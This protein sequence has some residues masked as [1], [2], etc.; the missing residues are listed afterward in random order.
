MFGR[1]RWPKK[2]GRLRQRAKRKGNGVL[3]TSAGSA[4][5]GN[6]FFAAHAAS[7]AALNVQE[8]LCVE[9]I[10]NYSDSHHNIEIHITNYMLKINVLNFE[11]MVTVTVIT[12]VIS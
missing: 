8:K 5:T 2:S 9:E 3:A 12:R 10:K 4:L 6:P 1:R 7:R 11:V